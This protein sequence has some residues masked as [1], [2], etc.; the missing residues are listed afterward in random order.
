M[1]IATHALCRIIHDRPAATRV[2]PENAILEFAAAADVRASE[3]AC[4]MTA[5]V[6]PAIDDSIAT[7]ARIRAVSLPH[8]RSI[9]AAVGLAV[10]DRIATARGIIA[11]SSPHGPFITAAQVGPV[12]EDPTTAARCVR[13]MS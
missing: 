7:A 9:A 13:A 10:V 5:G 4:S 8:D 1:S 3:K 2:R 12:V 11:V 6:V